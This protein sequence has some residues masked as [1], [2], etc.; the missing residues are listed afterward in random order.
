M[1]IMIT[2]KED[3]ILFN[4]FGG[5]K[6]DDSTKAIYEYMISNDKLGF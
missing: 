4:C 5:Q 2:V 1:K 6:F 3:I